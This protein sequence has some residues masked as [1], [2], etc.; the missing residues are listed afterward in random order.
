MDILKYVLVDE[1]GNEGDF[2]YA[3]FELAKAA[4]GN[5]HAVLERK[6][7]YE[8]SELAW[9]PNGDDTWPPGKCR[10]EPDWKSV[11]INSGYIDVNC[12]KCGVSGCIGTSTTLE[13][14][15][16]WEEQDD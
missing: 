13:S 7:C 11:T 6:Y 14:D 3:L 12:E 15:I 1:N 10:H 4:A 9:T 8:D 5:D 16:M 2:E